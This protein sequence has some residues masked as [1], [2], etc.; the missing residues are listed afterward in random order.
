MAW[1]GTSS[2]TTMGRYPWSSTDWLEGA[3]DEL[4]LSSA[5]LTDAEIHTL[6]LSTPVGSVW[7]RVRVWVRGQGR[8]GDQL[9]RCG[10]CGV[11]QRAVRAVG[12]ERRG[13]DV[14]LQRQGHQVSVCDG[15]DAAAVVPVRRV[16]AVIVWWHWH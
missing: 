8:A 5:Q 2:N 11:A 4:L 16:G 1:T 15:G 6:F 3:V 13:A 10:G 12:G 9:Q 14:L 7:M